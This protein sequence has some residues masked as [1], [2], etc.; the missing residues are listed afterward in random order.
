V[1]VPDINLLIYAYDTASPFHSKAKTWWEG[2]L[3]GNQRVGLLT[4]VALGFIR[5]ATHPRIFRDPL[6]V[7]EAAGH[8]RAWMGRPQ[9]EWLEP[10]SGHIENVLSLLEG[11]GTAGNLV[12]DAQ[13]AAAALQH[14]AVLHTTDAD[15]TRFADLRWFNPI[16]GSGRREQRPS[17]K[18]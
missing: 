2:C 10:G 12:T 7:T 15:F 16:T 18:A 4:V 6:S 13:L 14:D 11:I 8:V 5:I 3:N 1:I 17:P 9:V